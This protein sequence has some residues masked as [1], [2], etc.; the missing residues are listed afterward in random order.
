MLDLA[1]RQLR[2]I[3][4][5]LR[6]AIEAGVPII[7]LEPSCVSVFRDELYNL[8]PTNQDAL[9]LR[10]QVVT[11]GEFLAQRNRGDGGDRRFSPPTLARRAIVH[12]HCH[13]KAIMRMQGETAVLDALG[14]DYQVLDDGCCGMAG[15][16]GFEAEK[17]ELSEAIG[18][19]ALL[20]AVRQASADTLIIADGFSCREQIAQSTDRRALHTAQVVQL[21]M[22]EGRDVRLDGK[23][24][25]RALD[26]LRPRTLTRPTAGSLAIAATAGGLAI[27][28]GIVAWRAIAR[29]GATRQSERRGAARRIES[30]EPR[31]WGTRGER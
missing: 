15:S 31:D 22:H 3:M 29:R 17:Y 16:F 13:D 9:R 6:P 23:P 14:L 18:E 27:A 24:P 7:G 20:P 1:K 28:G 19:R 2:E 25:E 5:T 4:R 10:G 11:L 21:A 30:V 26:R 12:G 8:F